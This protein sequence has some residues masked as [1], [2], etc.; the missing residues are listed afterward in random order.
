[1]QGFQLNAYY[2]LDNV[3][4]FSE[5]REGAKLWSCNIEYVTSARSQTKNN[6]YR[7]REK[8]KNI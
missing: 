8:V 4:G 1:M 5:Q 2:V 7:E 3:L 6:I